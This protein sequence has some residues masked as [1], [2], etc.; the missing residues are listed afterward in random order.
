MIG[1]R[2]ERFS[3]GNLVGFYES[4]KK[5]VRLKSLHMNFYG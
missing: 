3:E 2:I 5:L 1:D 4:L